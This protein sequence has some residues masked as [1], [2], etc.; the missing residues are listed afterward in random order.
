MPSQWTS[1]SKECL[2]GLSLHDDLHASEVS[3]RALHSLSYAV[4]LFRGHR[5]VR[6]YQRGR[7]CGK[8]HPKM[9]LKPSLLGSGTLFG[10]DE[11]MLL[12]KS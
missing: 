10:S 4:S 6:S 3:L 7:N 9:G 12:E 2:V 11:A 8:R 1:R 5:E